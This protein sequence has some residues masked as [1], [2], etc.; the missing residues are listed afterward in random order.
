MKNTVEQL[1]AKMRDYNRFAGTMIVLGIY[2][3]I[4]S[5]I[6]IYIRLASGGTQFALLSL[7]FT[8]AGFML[9]TNA[10]RIK[11]EISEKDAC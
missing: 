4:G 11:K 9:L 3:Y 6:Q 7:G 10:N 1:T 5:L 8:L 2:F